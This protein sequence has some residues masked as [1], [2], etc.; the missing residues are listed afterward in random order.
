MNESI[1]DCLEEDNTY[2]SR[3]NY[4]NYMN[5]QNIYE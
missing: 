2:K 5:S 1:I 3:E 4:I